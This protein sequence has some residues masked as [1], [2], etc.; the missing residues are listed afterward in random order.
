MVMM[1]ADNAASALFIDTNILVYANVAEA[2]LHQ[3]AISALQRAHQ[4][5]R[6]LWLSRQVLREFA[7]VRSRPQSFSHAAEPAVIV[8]RLRFFENNFN[9][10]DDTSAVSSCLQKLII[11]I[12][13]GGKQVHD[14]NIVA[15][16][17]AFDITSLLTHNHG[18]F[19]RYAAFITTEGI[20]G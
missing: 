17:M 11:G 12:P 7:A 9:V 2:P 13:L 10:A 5:G 20:T 8:E 18:D 14:A 6:S 4:H 19:E 3:Q 16:M 1:V 15:T